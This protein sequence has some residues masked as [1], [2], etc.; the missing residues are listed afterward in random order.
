MTVED[1]ICELQQQDRDAEVRLAQQPAWAFEY[2]L[3][4]VTSA[5]TPDGNIV[6]IAEGNQ[7]GYLPQEAK[8]AVGWD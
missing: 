3:D 2:D 6:Y 8:E 4:G 1:L 7:L 5:N